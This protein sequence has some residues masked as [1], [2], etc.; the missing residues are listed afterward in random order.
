VV[1]RSRE[2]DLAFL[3]A[4]LAGY[5]ALTEA[6]GDLGAAKV[7]AR[8]VEI[9]REALQPGTRLVERVGDELLVVGEDVASI[10]RTATCLRQAV[11]CEPLF[12][13][14]RAG[15]HAGGV[16][17]HDGKYLGAVVNLTARVAA[18]A[19]AGQILCTEPVVRRAER[20][21]EIEYRKIGPVR[22]RNIA[23]PVRVFE[24]MTGRQ[25]GERTVVDPVCRMQVT[26]ETAPARLPYGEAT[27]FFCSFSCAQAFAQR[28]NSYVG[29]ADQR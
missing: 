22:F 15:M 7:I 4:D 28:P 26:P 14:V 11:E 6:M 2:A 1:S 13:A 20:L 25:C 12:P 18:H 27:Y 9:A 21:P 8:Y 23:D 24:V 16:L 17:E 29:P 19:A 5:T 10:V 3:I